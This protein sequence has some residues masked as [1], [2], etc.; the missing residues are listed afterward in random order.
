[1]KKKEYLCENNEFEVIKDI[2][3]KVL[4]KARK[5]NDK[6][7]EVK[8]NKMWNR[9]EKMKKIED[10]MP[11]VGLILF[12]I[13]IIILITFF[14]GEIHEDSIV[15]TFLF[16][17]ALTCWGLV[18]ILQQNKEEY[19][20]AIRTK[21]RNNKLLDTVENYKN[22]EV[23]KIIL[24]SD[25]C[26]VTYKKSNGVCEK[27]QLG[28]DIEEVSV[29]ADVDKVQVYF[30]YDTDSE[31]IDRVLVPCKFLKKIKE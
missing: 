10:V 11:V 2:D 12:F 22:I 19:A 21:I 17:I 4:A 3:E 30:K 9:L 27:E 5:F 7:D 8:L 29:C 13:G 6:Y 26:I 28:W 1:M 31:Y 15:L 18:F 14:S 25:G 24:N 23:L 16:C 20:W